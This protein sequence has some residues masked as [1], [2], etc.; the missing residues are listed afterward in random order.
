[1]PQLNPFGQLLPDEMGARVS[2]IGVEAFEYV[3]GSAIAR[4]Q[5]DQTKTPVSLAI[6]ATLSEVMDTDPRELSPLHSSIDPAALDALLERRTGSD[7]DV[8][9]EFS[10]ED[11]A[12]EV[13]SYGVI[14]VSP[15]QTGS[16]SEQDEPAED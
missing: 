3:R 14:T 1:M 7:G 2:G 15:P 5:F 6:V 10:H 9:V 8:F 16:P 13:N 4:T 12:I 11:H